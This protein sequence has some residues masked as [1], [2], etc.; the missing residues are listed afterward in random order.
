MRL[1]IQSTAQQH[2]IEGNIRI[3]DA[4]VDNAIA[5]LSE[6]TGHSKVIIRFYHNAGGA[7]ETTLRLTEAIK[8][9]HPH[10]QVILVFKG[11]VASAAAFILAT[12]AFRATPAPNVIVMNEGPVC[13]VFHKPRVVAGKYLYFS[14]SLYAC[15]LYNDTLEFLKL[16]TPRFD[17]LF[18]RMMNYCERKKIPLAPH[19]AS[20]YAMNGDVTLILKSGKL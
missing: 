3:N 9:C 20:V 12:F 18:F 8:R 6:N 13:V 5:S 19:M 1:K 17:E 7:I 15:Q 11:Y 16:I 4:R 14:N 10:R 2:L